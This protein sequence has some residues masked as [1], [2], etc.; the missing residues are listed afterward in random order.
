MKQ[1]KGRQDRAYEGGKIGE[2]KELNEKGNLSARGRLGEKDRRR[3]D[4]RNNMKRRIR[5]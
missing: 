3:N 5:M 2:L 1:K 4:K